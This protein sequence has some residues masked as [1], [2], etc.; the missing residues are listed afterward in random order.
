MEIIDEEGQR[1]SMGQPSQEADDCF[2]TV[3]AGCPSGC[4]RGRTETRPCAS[5]RGRRRE[6]LRKRIHHFGGKFGAETP[7]VARGEEE[8]TYE[9]G[10]KCVIR[11][12]ADSARVK[13]Q[14]AAGIEAARDLREEAALPRA[15]LSAEP[16]E[17]R[18]TAQGFIEPR[19]KP[20]KLALS[21]AQRNCS[22][23][24][25]SRPWPRA[26]AAAFRTASD[27]PDLV[28]TKIHLS[29]CFGDRRRGGRPV[30][31][32]PFDFFL[33]PI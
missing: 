13:G 26:R 2:Y 25:H 10:E 1:S 11:G 19:I 9:F 22:W 24:L 8:G 4:R 30:S 16:N 17:T 23:V 7:R 6:Q 5:G 29:P 20:G 14:I 21:S 27:A 18:L 31:P 15:G 3:G 33:R 12:A 32:H 28:T